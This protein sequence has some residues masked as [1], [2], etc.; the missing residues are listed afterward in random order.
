MTDW[1][2][3]TNLPLTAASVFIPQRADGAPELYRAKTCLPNTD[4]TY[5]VIDLS[6][7]TNA[8]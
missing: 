1:Y 8:P 4:G 2:W 6:V 5:T 3:K 7:F